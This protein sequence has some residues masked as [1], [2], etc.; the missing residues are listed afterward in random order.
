MTPLKRTT[1]SPKLS[2]LFAAMLTIGCG[3][4]T[5]P[6]HAEE[7]AFVCPTDDI[8]KCDYENESMDIFIKGRD[9]Y[10][11]GREI[12]DLTEARELA[13]KLMARKN[14]NGKVL[15]KMIYMQIGMGG[16]KNYPEAYHWV[17]EAIANKESY[18]R[19]DMNG[20]LEKLSQRMTDAERATLKT[21]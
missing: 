10:D 4:I 13:K 14:K 21:K 19:L 2:L 7:D 1:R 16:H 6:A 3:S 20:L 9:A 5:A 11:H 17:E 8:K 12:G 15:M 18:A